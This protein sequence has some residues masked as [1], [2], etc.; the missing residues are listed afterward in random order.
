MPSHITQAIRAPAAR[1]FACIEDP[2]L[3]KQWQAGLEK[4]VYSHRPEGEDPT[5]TRF[6]A[7]I[8]EGG[9]IAEY[10]GE[11]TAY[12]K[13]ELLEV[14]MGNDALTMRIRYGIEPLADDPQACAVQVTLEV[15]PR[16]FLARLLLPLGRPLLARIART[17]LR[18]L[19]AL[20]ER[21]P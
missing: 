9:R 2:A 11:L 21:R 15:T 19:K 7:R 6:T 14:L 3:R 10:Q 17:Q 20:A 16:S 5:G 1:V 18:A 4:T 8:R 12:R 13:P